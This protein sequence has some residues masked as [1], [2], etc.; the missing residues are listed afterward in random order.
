MHKPAKIGLAVITLTIAALPSRAAAAPSVPDDH[1]IAH[2]TGD[3]TAVD[4]VAGYVGTLV[5]DVGYGA[6]VH[7]DA[8]SFDGFGDRVVID[9]GPQ[10]SSF[11]IMMWVYF[12]PT[13]RTWPWRTL[14]APGGGGVWMY[15]AGTID[16]PLQVVNY[17]EG[18]NRYI[19]TLPIPIEGWAH[20]ALTY[21]DS[22]C[23][24]TGF[25]D[26]VQDASSTWCTSLPSGPDLGIGGHLYDRE[27]W[28]GY[29]DDV[30]VY[31]MPLTAAEVLTAAGI[32]LD[33]DA[34]GFVDSLDPCPSI[35][36]PPGGSGCP[37]ACNLPPELSYTVDES[38]SPVGV[39]INGTP[40]DDLILGSKFA[41]VINGNGGNDLVCAGKGD[42]EVYSGSGD[43]LIDVG[44]GIDIA[45]AGDG[46]NFVVGG[47]GQDTITT[48][49][50]R[51]TINGGGGTNTLDAGDG[52]NHVFGGVVKDIITTGSGNDTIDAG[53]GTN[54]VNAGAG[55]NLVTGGANKDVVTTGSGNDT[56]HL[57]DGP[58]T[59]TAGDGNNTVTGG[60]GTD[61]VTTGAG[62]DFVDVG[63]GKNR[64]KT[65][66]G[67]DEIHVT[68]DGLV[69]DRDRI[70]GGTGTDTCV[71][72]VDPP[73]KVEGCEL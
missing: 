29:I 67:D 56:L 6:G 27:D 30:R 55:D 25:V 57:G 51:D 41:D 61:V 47:Q 40:G 59:A 46:D 12:E 48:G 45:V 19:G 37:D 23:T 5:G 63:G 31:D 11:T 32:T 53:A 18:D 64:V 2:W 17:W 16:S 60:S 52:T 65:G 73:D 42:D 4:E 20:V 71:G 33:K 21:D 35:W 3:G 34:D 36:G 7:G 49:A 13:W 24:L 10:S 9:P 68:V 62:S 70:D 43:D 26:G 8:F 58:N 39:S 54:L 66:D 50:G 28:S 69:T 14:Y 44:S 15:N 72:A 22:T 1:L 38:S